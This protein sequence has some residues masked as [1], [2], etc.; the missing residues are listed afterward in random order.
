[1]CWL[2]V[3]DLEGSNSESASPDPTRAASLWSRGKPMPPQYWQRAWKTKAWIRRLSGLI[4]EPSTADRGVASWIASLAATRA[5]TPA[6]QASRQDLTVTDGLPSKSFGSSMRCGLL[7]S[8][9]RTSQ[10]LPTNSLRPSSRHWSDWATALHADYSQRQNAAEPIA[11]NGSSSWPT[12]DAGLRDGFNTSPGP[13]GP[14]PTLMRATQ[15]WPTPRACS[16]KRSSGANRTELVE[17]WATPR[18]SD[19]N[20]PGHHGDGGPD[21]RT[22]AA[23]WPT[24]TASDWK[25]SGP[26]L[27]RRDGKMRG[28]RLDYATEQCFSPPD[29]QTPDGPTSS[30]ER[31]TLNPQFVEWLQN[32]PAGWTD[33]GHAVTGFSQWLRRSRGHL[34]MLCSRK[35]T[36]PS[37]F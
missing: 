28:D 37:L 6:L 23:N 29:P 18:S 20:G 34:S 30:N 7:V 3:P 27:E 26:T 16:G 5:R 10:G 35:P 22:M 4:L 15:T 31:R 24:A 36:Q 12:P 32:W 8:S 9:E 25:G 11:G 33:C 2:F 13:A 1:M 19:T 14:R 21:V 17:A